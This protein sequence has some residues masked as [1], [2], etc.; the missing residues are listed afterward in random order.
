MSF[1]IAPMNTGLSQL[2]SHFRATG[3]ESIFSSVNSEPLLGSLEAIYVMA[4]EFWTT[5]AP[6][7]SAPAIAA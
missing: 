5:T 4:A 6:K 3:T 1:S 2:T 7:T